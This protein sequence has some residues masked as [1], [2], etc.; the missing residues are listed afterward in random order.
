MRFSRRSVL[1][2]LA[3]LSFA[4]AVGCNNQATVPGGET[5]PTSATPAAS[6][7]QVVNV[8][9]A[10]H[11]DTDEILY[12]RFTE[13]TG[14]QVNIIEGE[15]DELI[16]R[17]K[18]E[19]VNS[20]ADLLVTVDA[21]RLWRAEEEGLFQ[22][23]ESD[24]LTSAIPENL[25]H[26]DNLWFGLTT[27]ARVIAYNKETVDPSELS[28]YEDLAD[29]KWR[30]RVCV[31]SSTNIYNQSLLGSMI[32]TIGPEATEE[33]AK[34]LV[35]NFAR[36]PEGGD[37]DQIKAVAAGQCDVAIVN[38]YYWARLA[39][40]DVPEEK[41]VADAVGIFFPNQ[42]DRGTH[43]NISGAGVLVNAP[44]RDNAIAFLEYLVSPEAQEIFASSN[45]EYPVLEGVAVDPIVAELGN[46]KVDAVNVSSYGRNNPEVLQIVDRVGW[47]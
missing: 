33:W 11:Y 9:S 8:Y 16:E 45:N 21:G 31:R 41:E 37:T 42:N 20:P 44:H 29:P 47:K 43:I 23:I 10:R 7:E 24:V 32:E 4:L 14:I 34:G 15:A 3:G 46:F 5:S 6:E 19:G 39:K 30:G 36:E 26:P 2:T 27:R 22:P 28:T 12:D 40:S 13:E 38:H 17:I 35:A 18:S 1:V 25:R